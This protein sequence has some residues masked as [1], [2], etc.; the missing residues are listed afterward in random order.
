LTYE[1]Y[2]ARVVGDG[3]TL[4]ARACTISDI[5]ELKQ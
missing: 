5:N 3:G 1:P 2:A 4:E